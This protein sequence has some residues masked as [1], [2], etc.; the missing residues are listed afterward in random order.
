[1]THIDSVNMRIKLKKR[2]RIWIMG[3]GA[4]QPFPG[5]VVLVITTWPLRSAVIYFCSE[6]TSVLTLFL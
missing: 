1:M 3:E 4:L 6:I 2:T 5:G